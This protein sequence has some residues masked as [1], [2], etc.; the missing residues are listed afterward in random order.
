M[1]FSEKELEE[2][3][4]KNKEFIKQL[5]EILEIPE[6]IEVGDIIIP[7]SG[8]KLLVIEDWHDEKE[9]GEVISYKYATIYTKSMY[10]LR[11]YVTLEELNSEYRGM[12][13]TKFISKESLRVLVDNLSKGKTCI[14]IDR[15]RD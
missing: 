8:I 2:L 14:W 6:K 9:F 3:K 13:G 15:E 5:E 10:P 1:E 12:P 4:K 7:P 11:R